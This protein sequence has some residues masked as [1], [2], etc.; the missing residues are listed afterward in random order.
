MILYRD[1]NT[2]R[3]ITRSAWESMQ[4]AKVSEYDDFYGDFEPDLEE[5][6]SFD[7][8]EVY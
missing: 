2:G 1:P 8:D 4:G 3:F 5:W 6:D 7:E